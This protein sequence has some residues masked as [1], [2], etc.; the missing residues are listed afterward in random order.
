MKVVDP[1]LL[2]EYPFFYCNLQIEKISGPPEVARLAFYFAK[3]G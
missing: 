3:N 2:S 1:S